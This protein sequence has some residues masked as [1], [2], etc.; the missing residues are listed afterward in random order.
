MS[1]PPETRPHGLDFTLPTATAVP[2]KRL[3]TVG[4]AVFGILGVLLILGV[5]K[6][7]GE[8]NALVESVAGA[9]HALLRVEVTTPAV[10]SSDRALSLPGSVQALQTTLLYPRASGYVKSYSID[11][12]DKVKTGQV[13]AI[14]ETPELDQ[15][16]AQA[17][18]Q[19]L[20]TQANVALSKA[21][22]D[23]AKANYGRAARLAPSGVVSKADL[24]TTQAQ[25]EVGEANVK[26]ADANVTAQ[27]ANIN[28]LRQLKSFAKVTAPFDGTITTRTIEVGSLV[29]A[30]NAS[31]LFRLAA[32]DP[33]RVFVQVPQDVAPGV[34]PGVTSDVTV[35][36]YPGKKFTGTVARAAGELDAQTRT[37]NTEIRVPNK[38]NLLLAGMYA[39]VALTLPSPH[40]VFQLPATSLLSDAKGQR[41]AVIDGQDKV[42][43][44]PVVVERDNG[45]TLDIASGLTGTERVA[46][47]ASA[48]FVDGMQVE[49]SAPP[50]QIPPS[51]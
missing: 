30:G 13:L 35:R 36:E 26:V 49:V 2:K 18:A 51:K 16:L 47:L 32:L 9:Q 23:L 17:N 40:R 42:H 46:K 24:E 48:A 31:P 21:N 38:E 28:R 11:I 27:Q 45:A 20:Q 8:H 5:L 3:F 44:T 29:T 7:R 15:E 34:R 1:S 14:I 10:T 37:M 22:R 19:L 4:L 39:E 50:P 6:R 33:A 12:G 43:L 41:V 25:A